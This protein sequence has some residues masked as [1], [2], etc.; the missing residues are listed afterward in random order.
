MRLLLVEDDQM[1]GES[2]VDGLSQVGYQVDWVFDGI[3]AESTILKQAFDIIVLDLGLPKKQGLEVLLNYRRK[4]G[5]AAILIITARDTRLDLILGLDSGADDYLVKPF[6]LDELYARLRALIRRCQMTQDQVVS[7]HGLTLNLST[8]E[9]S[10]ND[11]PIH[12][13]VLEFNL[14]LA[15]LETPGHVVSKAKLED[16]VYGLNDDIESNTI[17]VYIHMLRKK[18]GPNFIKNVRGV[19]YKLTNIS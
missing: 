5:K 3:E 11:E 18:F 10:F 9:A 15:L 12:L 6:D 4:K 7:H 8:H 13:S 14:M 1:I 16:K 19:G 17:E 2:L